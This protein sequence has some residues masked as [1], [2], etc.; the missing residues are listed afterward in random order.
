VPATAT[1]EKTADSVVLHGVSWKLYDLLVNEL[2]EEHVYLTYDRGTLEIM[3]PQPRHEEYKWVISRWLVL[4]AAELGLDVRPG[5]NTTFRREDRERGLEPDDCFWIASEPAIRGKVDLDFS[6]DPPPD[7]AIEIDISR[8]GVDRESIYA[9]LGVPELWRYNGRALRVYILQPD[10]TYR[11]SGKSKSFPF[12][13]LAEF[14]AFLQRP[15]GL[16][17]SEWVRSFQ[18]WVRTNLKKK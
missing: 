12:L 11:S 6:V 15:A 17:E 14:Q 1:L 9:A 5:G 4:L 10:G 18:E 13:P 16:S 8:H 2:A 3:S 7:L